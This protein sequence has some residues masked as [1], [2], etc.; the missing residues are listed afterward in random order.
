MN[1]RERKK[2]K[3]QIV[4]LL[5]KTPVL[6][7]VCARVGIAR[8]TFYRWKDDDLVFSREVEEALENGRQTINDL[9]IS[10][11]LGKI[12]DGDNT[13]I[14]FWLKHNH[15]DFYKRPL[16]IEAVKPEPTLSPEKI[17]EMD[18]FV[19]K[20]EEEAIEAEVNSR[21]KMISEKAVQTNESS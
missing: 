2:V 4:E 13:C 10:Q 1:K 18:A 19:R 9:A 12:K 7:S 11:L 8:S 21:L 20:M 17:A 16:R 6:L 3:K 14:I 5:D 15:P